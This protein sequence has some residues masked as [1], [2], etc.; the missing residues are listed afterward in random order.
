MFY[1]IYFYHSQSHQDRQKAGLNEGWY[2][3]LQGEKS[4]TYTPTII[5]SVKEQ[6]LQD[7]L[8]N[9]NEESITDSLKKTQ[10]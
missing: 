1:L 5:K 3:D 9:E 10:L 7:A 6:A 4:S 2:N 8:N